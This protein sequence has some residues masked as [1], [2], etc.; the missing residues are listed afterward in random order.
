MND[1]ILIIIT[2]RL[3]RHATGRKTYAV[4]IRSKCYKKA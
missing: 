3:S 1:R 2:K 4:K